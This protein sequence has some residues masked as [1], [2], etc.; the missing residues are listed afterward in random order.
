MME[1]QGFGA[2][3][4]GVEVFLGRMSDVFVFFFSENKHPKG[5]K[6]VEEIFFFNG[7]FFVDKMYV[8]K[9]TEILTIH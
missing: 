7:V 6:L 1:A 5:W 9:Y 8:N 4:V 2:V 3:L